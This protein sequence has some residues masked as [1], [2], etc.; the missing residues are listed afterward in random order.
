MNRICLGVF[1]FEQENVGDI[2]EASVGDNT[3]RGNFAE[4][5]EGLG[6]VLFEEANAFG[7]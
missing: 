7:V 3:I 1:L 5:R 6:F 2:E 4:G